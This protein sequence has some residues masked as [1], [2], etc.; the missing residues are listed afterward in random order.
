MLAGIGLLA[1]ACGP[2]GSGSLGPVPTP[3]P[4]AV[5]SVPAHP[6]PSGTA[7][8]APSTASASPAASTHP[9]GRTVSFQA[10]FARAGRL[11]VTQRTEPYGQ[12]VGQLALRAVLA[13]P[14]G[15]EAAA[16]LVSDI[17]AGTGLLGVKI[18]GGTATVSLS[19]AFGAGATAQAVK[20]RL[21]QVVYTITQFASA[22]RVSFEI[23]GQAARV[24]GG[25]S[26]TRPQTRAAYAPLLPPITVSGPLIGAQVTSP[27]TVSGTADVFEA[28]VS[29]RILDSAGHEIARSFT[30]A[31]CGT[32]CRGVYS[33]AVTYSVRHAEQGTIQVYEVSAK[34][35]LPVN[36]QSI[37]VTLLP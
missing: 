30:S 26:V 32:G 13:G 37:P 29:L 14:T 20:L 19:S 17:P 9:A 21:A 15:G 1:C 24:I 22:T 7:S 25:I 31:S 18:A 23:N 3:P 6:S 12:G 4:A 33:V 34:T 27:V 16:G 28:V 8:P 5:S 11:F 35:G 36:V 10:W 2:A